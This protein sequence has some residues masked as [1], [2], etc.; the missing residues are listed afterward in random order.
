MKSEDCPW[1]NEKYGIEIFISKENDA[2]ILNLSHWPLQNEER[3]LL[4]IKWCG[5][6]NVWSEFIFHG[7]RNIGDFFLIRL[8]DSPY[9]NLSR[10]DLSG[11]ICITDAS[12]KAISSYFMRLSYLDLSDCSKIT[13]AGL[14]MI[15]D[16]CKYLEELR[17]RNLHHLQDEGMSY[18]IRNLALMKRLRVFGKLKEYLCLVD[19]SKPTSLTPPTI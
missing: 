14:C 6:N 18:I 11:C 19:A 13:D 2:G 16:G 10:L 4:A 8:A 15:M 5:S 12:C 7:C 1:W 3:I 9:M 17:L